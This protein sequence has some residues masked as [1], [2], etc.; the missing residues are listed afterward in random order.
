MIRALAEVASIPAIDHWENT[1][2]EKKGKGRGKG[3]SNPHAKEKELKEKQ[4]QNDLVKVVKQIEMKE[5]EKKLAEKKEKELK[6]N[7]SQEWHEKSKARKDGPAQ[8][9]T[10]SVN[11]VSSKKKAKESNNSLYFISFFRFAI[12]L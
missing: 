8:P 2:G 10:A 3:K 12:F 9:Y 4:R 11:P 7:K 5:M 1:M 6:K